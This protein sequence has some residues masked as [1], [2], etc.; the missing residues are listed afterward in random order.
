MLG[1]R[2]RDSYEELAGQIFRAYVGE[3]EKE[4]VKKEDCEMG[5]RAYQNDKCHEHEVEGVCTRSTEA[6]RASLEHVAVL[7]EEEGVHDQPQR[8]AS[9]EEA[10]YG[11]PQLWQ[12]ADGEDI[13][14]KEDDPGEAIQAEMSG[15]A[16]EDGCGCDGS[17]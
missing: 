15:H 6:R 7:V 13:V 11:A 16:D 2:N 8:R 3:R 9:D 17:A 14:S 5:S 10:R 12:L 1:S 4:K